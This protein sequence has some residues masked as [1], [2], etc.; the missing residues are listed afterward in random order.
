MKQSMIAVIVAV[1]VGIGAVAIAPIAFLVL[2]YGCTADDDRLA[3]SLATL[4]VLDAHPASATL[5]EGRGS[6]CDSDDRITTVWQTYRLSGPRADA[7]SFYRDVAIKEGWAPSPDDDGEGVSCFTKSFG[8]RDID[9]SV[10][11]PDATGEKYD[12]N[13]SSSP[14]GGGWGC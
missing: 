6:S 12:I 2:T 3:D 9:L 11:F 1:C 5:E 8:G 14:D 10:E 7:L 13:V 4:S